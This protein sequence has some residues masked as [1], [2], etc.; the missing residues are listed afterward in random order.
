[1]RNYLRRYVLV[2]AVLSILSA[3]SA[4]AAVTVHY[5][6]VGQADATLVE[7]SD[8]ALLIDAGGEFTG[9]TSQQ[10]HL[11][12]YLRDFFARRSDLNRTLNSVIITHPHIDH[13]R[14]LMSVLQRFKVKALIE[15]GQ[16]RG[17]GIHPLRMARAF[18]QRK[19]V[20]PSFKIA[21]FS[22]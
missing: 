16:K 9:D 13:T 12:G 19:G 6:N 11:T 15:G 20:T 10:D 5:I 8:G 2:V 17:S 21:N 22:L 7:F 3:L 14:H 1:M 4:S 18:A